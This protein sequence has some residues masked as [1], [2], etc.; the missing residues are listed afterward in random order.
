MQNLNKRKVRMSVQK[1]LHNI[2][3]LLLLAYIVATVL[4]A[5]SA[6]IFEKGMQFAHAQGATPVTVQ[7][8]KAHGR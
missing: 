6:L 1:L 3:S 8:S 5:Y 2:K 7:T 4:G